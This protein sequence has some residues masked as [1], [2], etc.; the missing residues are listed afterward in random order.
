MGLDQMAISLLHRLCE[1]WQL[2]EMGFAEMA[3]RNK[4]PK[5]DQPKWQLDK[6][7]LAEM[8][9]IQNGF[10]PNGNQTKWVQPKWDKLDWSLDDMAIRQW[11][12]A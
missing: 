6:M 9:I 1:L 5:W 10:R 11:Y 8:A 4:K 3:I 2:D 12:L 7:G